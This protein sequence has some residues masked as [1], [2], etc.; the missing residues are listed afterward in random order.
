MGSNW[1]ALSKPMPDYSLK[2]FER[3]G[4]RMKNRS[5]VLRAAIAVVNQSK[6]IIARSKELVQES[7]ILLKQTPPTSRPS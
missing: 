7:R 4:D 1:G 5:D 2:S 3:N 6:S